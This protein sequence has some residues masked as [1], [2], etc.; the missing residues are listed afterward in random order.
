MNLHI[1]QVLEEGQSYV[2]LEVSKDFQN[3]VWQRIKKNN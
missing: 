2:K 3:F 1:S